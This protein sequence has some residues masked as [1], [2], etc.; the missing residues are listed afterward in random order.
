[1]EDTRKVSYV[2]TLTFTIFAALLSIALFA[3]L[4]IKGGLDF[5]VF[6]TILEVGIFVIIFYCIFAIVNREKELGKMKDPKNY[7]I[8][9]DDCPSYYVK[10]YDNAT[11]KFFCSNE[12]V[13]TD[14]RNPT[15]KLI[16]K[17]Y[18]AGDKSAPDTHS[19]TFIERSSNGMTQNP[20]KW[21]KFM[22]NDMYALL[23]NDKD[24]CAAVTRDGEDKPTDKIQGYR[25]LPWTSVQQRCASLYGK[26]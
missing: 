3:V 19:Q 23:D 16:M 18:D 4:F 26:N 20:A 2:R 14:P 5:L 9:F 6:V 7:V 11:S 10:R 17:I 12:Y 22:V 15:S 21:D 13:V 1:M 8:K 24:R 25:T